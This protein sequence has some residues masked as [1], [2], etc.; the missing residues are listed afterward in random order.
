MEICSN[1]NRA[2]LPELATDDEGDEIFGVCDNYQEEQLC[3]GLM[4]RL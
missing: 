4:H 2:G 3:D 1:M